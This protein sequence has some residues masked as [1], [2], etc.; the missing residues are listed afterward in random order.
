MS[1]AGAEVQTS[2]RNR[3]TEIDLHMRFLLLAPHGANPPTADADAESA[4]AENTGPVCC[5]PQT[6]LHLCSQA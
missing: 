4:L 1:F 5:P 6:A 2:A 3:T